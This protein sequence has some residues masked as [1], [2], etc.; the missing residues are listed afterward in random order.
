MYLPPQ[1]YKE[2]IAYG[3][4]E[5]EKRE[6]EIKWILYKKDATNTI[7]ILP[8]RTTHTHLCT[9]FIYSHVDFL[10]SCSFFFFSSRGW[11]SW[12][13]VCCPPSQLY[14]QVSFEHDSP[15]YLFNQGDLE[16]LPIFTNFKNFRVRMNPLEEFRDG[17]L[18]FLF[19]ITLIP[20]QID[21]HGLWGR[22]S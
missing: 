1:R 16:I 10:T 8:T 6:M 12:T 5:R 14:W 3:S 13:C 4:R 17:A 9:R 15:V 18:F 21:V 2:K 11:R 20:K 22:L 19:Y 7:L